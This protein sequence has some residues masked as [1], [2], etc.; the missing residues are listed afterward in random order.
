MRLKFVKNEKKLYEFD[1]EKV[2]WIQ[3]RNK[4]TDVSLCQQAVKW[5]PFSFAEVQEQLPKEDFIRI[6]ADIVVNMN[7]ITFMG[8]DTCVLNNGME[9]L[10]SRREKKSICQKYEDFI[11]SRQQKELQALYS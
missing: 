9:I 2:I 10:L 4:G 3:A 6:N 7:S 11:H 5:I 1:S 8:A